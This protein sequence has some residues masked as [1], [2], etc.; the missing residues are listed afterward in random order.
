MKSGGAC[1]HKS[2]FNHL[3]KLAC[4]TAVRAAKPFKLREGLTFVAEK[5]IVAAQA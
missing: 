3:Q 2:T 1:S 5:P 4:K